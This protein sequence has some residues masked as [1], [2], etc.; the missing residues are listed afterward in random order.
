MARGTLLGIRRY[1][2]DGVPANVDPDV[3]SHLRDLNALFMKRIF[4]R[5]DVYVYLLAEGRVAVDAMALFLSPPLQPRR[6]D[7]KWDKD[8]LAA[9]VDKAPEQ[10]DAITLEEWVDAEPKLSEL[11][12][13]V[14][15]ELDDELAGAEFNAK[16]VLDPAHSGIVDY[17]LA[18]AFYDLGVRTTSGMVNFLLR[19]ERG[20]ANV[21]RYAAISASRTIV[22]KKQ[23]RVPDV[24]DDDGELARRL[25]ERRPS[26]AAG[27]F[28]A[29]LGVVIDS[30]VFEATELGLIKKGQQALGNIEIKPELIPKLVRAIRSS[31]VKITNANV[32]NFL[33][34]FITQAAAESGG[35]GDA[36]DYEPAF[37]DLEFD[38]TFLA[39]GDSRAPVNDAAVKCAAQLFY[40]MVLGDELNVFDAVDYFTRR[41]LLREDLAITDKRLR[42]DLQLYVFSEKFT[43]RDPVTNRTRV[44]DRSRRDERAMFYRQVFA[45]GKGDVTEDM[46]VNEEFPR[47][48]KVLMF[49]SAQYLE[50]A[51]ESLHPDT[52]VSAQGVQQAVED[53]QYNLSVHCTGMANVMSPLLYEE[54]RFVTQRILSHPDVVRHVA[55]TGGTWLRAVERLTARMTGTRPRATVLNNKAEQGHNIIRQVAEYAPATFDDQVLMRFLSHVDGFIISQSILQDA[56]KASLHR[57]SPDDGFARRDQ[58]PSAGTHNGGGNGNGHPRG[59]GDTATYTVNGNGNGMVSAPRGERSGADTA[60]DEWDF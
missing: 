49:E 1:T 56:L 47:L 50:R 57:S 26:L 38:V 41:Y 19:N 25:T 60:S 40:A 36:E 34:L 37:S 11:K 23:L 43:A 46:L 10:P 53:L 58:G 32:E 9:L 13:E 42:D 51:R 48:W 30:L 3:A 5:N 52:F 24:D 55:P 4:P 27:P 35:A 14:L 20:I 39:T 45:Y 16:V 6:T 54:L 17:L 44:L 33:P 29:A 18:L 31:P 8:S 28:N 59:I 12:Y 21:A 7:E 2:S 15:E 22:A